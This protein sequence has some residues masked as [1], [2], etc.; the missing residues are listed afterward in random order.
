[1]KQ[2]MATITKRSWSVDRITSASD[3]DLLAR[4]KVC[5][6]AFWKSSDA[7]YT[8]P[9]NSDTDDVW[10]ECKRRGLY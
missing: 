8:L 9:Y 7:S 1:M 10:R 3:A 5:R 6:R 4:D 2:N